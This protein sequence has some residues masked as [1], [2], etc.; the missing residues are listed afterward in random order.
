MLNQLNI[1]SK[2]LFLFLL[3]L[4]TQAF[5]QMEAEV[6]INSILLQNEVI[7]KE[8]SLGKNEP[9]AIHITSI[10]DKTDKKELIARSKGTAWFEFVI[11]NQ[12][13]KSSDALWQFQK[14]E[15]R[16]LR[17][18]G[19]EYQLIFKGQ[20]EPVEGIF[21][22]IYQQ[23]FPNST[24]VR[25]K[26]KLKAGSKQFELNR[27]NGDLHFI[28]PNY[29]FVKQADKVIS[30]EINIARW[31][32]EVLDK[33]NCS[34]EDRRHG[35]NNLS[36]AHMYHPEVTERNLPMGSSTAFKGPFGLLSNGDFTV[37][38]AYEHASQDNLI[39]GDMIRHLKE[40]M[41]APSDL[42][43]DEDELQKLIDNKARF[44]SVSQ[45]SGQN[46]MQQGVCMER[47][48]Y[49]DGERIAPDKPYASVWS[50]TGHFFNEQDNQPKT[51]LHNYMMKWI[52]E[53]PHTREQEFYY[54]TWG[55][56]RNMPGNKLRSV[57]TYKRIFKE[58]RNAAELGVEIFVLDDGW[59]TRHGIWKPHPERL[60]KGL[61]P[62]RD[63]LEKYNMKL[64]V[65][66]N[67]VGI[68]KNTQRYKEH[69]EW[70]IRNQDGTPVSS[71]WGHPAFDFVSDYSDLFVED[72]KKL[73][74]QGVRFFKWDA[75]NTFYPNKPG[76]QH[77]GKNAG[78]EEIIARYGYKLPLYIKKAMVELMEYN[79]NVT[80]EIDLT[81]NRRA[82]PGLA[83]IS[84]GKLFWMNN[85]ASS[86]N[87]YTHYRAKS[88]RSIPNEF[89]G[90][91][92]LQLFTYANYP[93][94]QHPY[95]AQ[96]YNVNSSIAAGYGFWGNLEIMNPEER[97]RVGK[98][99]DKA[100]RVLDNIRYTQTEHIGRVG[101]SPEIY[102][103]VN[104]EKATGKILAFSGSALNY[105]HQVTVNPDR[106]LGVINNAYE[107]K[108]DQI[109]I[110][111]QFP[112]SLTSRE[113]FILPNNGTGISVLSSSCWLN[114][115]LID[116]QSL[117]MMPGGAGSISVKWPANISRPEV[118]G[119]N[120][121]YTLRQKPGHYLI[122]IRIKKPGE[123][124]IIR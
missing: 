61:K 99:V 70:V 123:T 13:V 66:L 60:N 94:N 11:N 9:A 88:M 78:K 43:K 12:L 46:S 48:G 120:I 30:R 36:Q 37:M 124:I 85:G 108:E 68:A 76:L 6:Q 52:T 64:G 105:E 84:A 57:L 86:Y 101:D 81:E 29:S 28:F 26:L 106:F 117:K 75:V 41:L 16:K 87:D 40:K 49:I 80:I 110:P 91:I 65:W 15:E 62:I 103:T 3:L 35:D 67:P 45:K 121:T 111:F 5:G 73:V 112:A 47:G 98:T 56:Q 25:E 54:N 97:K 83:M 122:K 96:R 79:P 38:T 74:D 4:S 2:I 90:I 31:N 118:E 10:Y 69:P 21:V 1:C 50:A 93:H 53:W 107:L 119:K 102:T 72:C 109:R 104:R 58:I 114:N 23:F 82:L 19:T 89:N 116:N 113:A 100:K 33:I 77:G 71:Q 51:L 63:T 18:G 39:E 59:E 44:L 22:H 95:F 92:P 14:V 34:A 55:M 17:N 20:S 24:L 27:L 32:D 115:L 8:I 7:K 42:E